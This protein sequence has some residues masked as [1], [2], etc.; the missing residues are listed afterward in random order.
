MPNIMVQG[1]ARTPA[2]GSG[3]YALHQQDDSSSSLTGWLK[4]ARL[5]IARSQQR[6]ALADLVEQDERMLRDI[7][8]SRAAAQREAAKPFWRR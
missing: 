8:V 3:R 1:W 5:W 7:G 6:E 2:Q 4:A